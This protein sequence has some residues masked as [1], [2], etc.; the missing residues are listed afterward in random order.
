MIAPARKMPLGRILAGAFVLPWRN[1]IGVMRVAGIPLMLVVA[2]MLAW[3]TGVFYELPSGQWIIYLVFSLT[4]AWLAIGVHRLVLIHGWQPAD[5]FKDWRVSRFAMFIGTFVA[6]WLLHHAVALSIA[7]VALNLLVLPR[8]VPTGEGAPPTVPESA[9]LYF[10]WLGPIASLFTYWV[11]G[12]LA[13][14]LPA[15]AVDRRPNVVE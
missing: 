1:R 3:H 9:Q 2:E 11:I 4:L 13:L 10:Y 7:S 6:L 5:G 12:R 15:I 14:V 8:Y